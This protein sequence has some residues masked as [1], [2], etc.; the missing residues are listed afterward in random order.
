MAWVSHLVSL[1]LLFVSHLIIGS[2]LSSSH[3]H[4]S[5][6]TWFH[7]CVLV[8]PVCHFLFVFCFSAVLFLCFSFFAFAFSELRPNPHS[9]PSPVRVGTQPGPTGPTGFSLLHF[10]QLEYMHLFSQQGAKG[11]LFIGKARRLGIYVCL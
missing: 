6:G 11:P 8:L 4:T 3:V 5:I 10:C 9:R 7:E 1:V 2:A